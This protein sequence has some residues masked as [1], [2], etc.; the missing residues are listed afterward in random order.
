MV[1]KNRD[2]QKVGHQRKSSLDQNLDSASFVLVR[3]TEQQFP[4]Q[5]LAVRLA[6]EGTPP[7]EAL[8]IQSEDVA[9]PLHHHVSGLL[10]ASGKKN[11][12]VRQSRVPN[13]SLGRCAAVLQQQLLAQVKGRR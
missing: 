1:L 9:V 5:V 2:A 12:S 4:Q 8:V 6:F 11:T 10:A 3:L 7:E 13:A